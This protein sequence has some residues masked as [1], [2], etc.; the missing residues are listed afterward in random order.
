VIAVE[1]SNQDIF[2]YALYRLQG[3][4]R[5]VDVEDVYVECF[6]LSPSRFG[7]RKHK[8]PNYKVASKAQRDFEGS[9]PEFIQ[10]TP[11][12]L[13]R[14]LTAEGVAWIRGHLESFERLGAGATRAPKTRRASHR[15]VAELLRSDAVQ[16]Y[17]AGET[18]ELSKVEIAE[19]F[20]C[21]PDSPGSVWQQ[22]L[23][24]VRA[25]AEDNERPDVLLFLDYVSANAPEWFGREAADK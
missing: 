8:Y 1:L 7:W 19:L 11:N 24:T 10:K 18:P 25:A 14:Q 22:R 2:A 23:A 17:L 15:V 9:H 3:A 6:N 4:G 16:S 21:A 5:F 12:G 13:S 20:N